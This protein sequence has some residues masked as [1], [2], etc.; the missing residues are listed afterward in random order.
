LFSRTIAG[1]LLTIG[2]VAFAILFVM[3][4]AGWGKKRTG[5]PTYFVEKQ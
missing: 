1:V 5:G 4:L 2:H 3:N